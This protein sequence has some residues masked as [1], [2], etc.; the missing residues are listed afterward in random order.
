MQVRYVVLYLLCL[1]ALFAYLHRGCVAIPAGMI[2]RELG[3]DDEEMA[4]IFSA[5]FWTYAAFQVPAGWL[6]DRLGSRQAVFGFT[7]LGSFAMVMMGFVQEFAAFVALR[8]LMGA[9]Q[10]GLFPA[11]VNSF[12]KWF[13]ASERGL[14]NGLLAAS[15]MLGA[16]IGNAIIPYLLDDA[17][18]TWRQIFFAFGVPSFLLA[19]YFFV[20]F[21]DR[22]EQHRNV[23]PAELAWIQH[24]TLAPSLPGDEGKTPRVEAR[25]NLWKGTGLLLIVLLCGQQFFRAAGQLFFSSWFP[26]FLL[27][28]RGV[29]FDQL[30]VFTSAPIAAMMIGSAVGGKTMDWIFRLTG[31]YLLSRQGLAMGCMAVAALFFA[32]PYWVE[33]PFAVVVLLTISCVAGGVGGPA[34]YT[35]TIDLGGK[36]VAT[37]FSIMNMA[38]NIGAAFAPPIAIYWR[39]EFGWNAVLLLHGGFF[40][41]ALLC[42]AAMCLPRRPGA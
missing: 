1:F 20:W 37:V 22:P 2:Q 40:A 7:V 34:A 32:L 17:G 21:R 13:P 39:N 28:A 15:M 35:M 12:T 18:Y 3:I 29:P 9:A 5:F 16:M 27:E 42:W 26:K 10:A 25:L 30:G 41:A 24:H 11:S 14:P 19:L 4:L 6:A 23:T 8:M 33:S 31:S 36:N 38:G